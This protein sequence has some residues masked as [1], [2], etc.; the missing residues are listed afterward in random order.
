MNKTFDTMPAA[1]MTALGSFKITTGHLRLSDPCYTAHERY[2]PV[3]AARPGKW[4]AMAGEPGGWLP[5]LFLAHHIDCNVNGAEWE[6]VGTVGVDSGCFG[7]FDNA[8]ANYGQDIYDRRRLSQL[9][10]APHC[11]PR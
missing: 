4:Q 3:I 10:R 2:A 7:V 5:R 6:E 9:P 8:F 1:A 11:K